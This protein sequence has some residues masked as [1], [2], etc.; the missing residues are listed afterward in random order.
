[1]PCVHFRAKPPSPQGIVFDFDGVIVN[2]EPLHLQ[3]SRDALAMRR[4]ELSDEYYE[5]YV[6]VTTWDVQ[7]TGDR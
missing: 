1:M 2:T 6:G 4:I 3:A 7:A 5:R